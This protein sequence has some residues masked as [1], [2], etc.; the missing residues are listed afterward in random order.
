MQELMH[1]YGE[2]VCMTTEVVV[3]GVVRG[4]GGSY[5]IRVYVR[6]I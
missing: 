4:L 1:K 2:H 5:G 6:F 3:S